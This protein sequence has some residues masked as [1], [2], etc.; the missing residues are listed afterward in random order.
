MHAEDM[1]ATLNHAYFDEETT[2]R[3]RLS[4]LLETVLDLWIHADCCANP[5]GN[6]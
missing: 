5:T 4:W 6:E 1:L 2:A 3:C